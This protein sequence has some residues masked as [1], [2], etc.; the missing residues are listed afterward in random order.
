MSLARLIYLSDSNEV[1]TWKLVKDILSV[2]QENNKLQNITG[3]LLSQGLHFLQVLEGEELDIQE[4]YTHIKNDRRH[5]NLQ[6]LSCESIDQRQF[7]E[8]SM[9]GVEFI[10][11]D[12]DKQKKILDKYCQGGEDFYLPE[13]P[14]QCIQLINDFGL[15]RST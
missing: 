9:K 4:L 13:D 14:Q 8:W 11:F 10:D 12:K 7:G 6:L 5:G 15:T 1:I 2:A 3:I